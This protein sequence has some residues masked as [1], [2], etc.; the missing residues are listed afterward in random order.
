MVFKKIVLMEFIKYFFLW[1]L[2]MNFYKT[3]LHLA[4]EQGNSKIVSFLLAR[5]E[6][7]VNIKSIFKLI[8]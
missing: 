3:V 7:D 2:L 5:P 4:I 1:N 8:F 6:I